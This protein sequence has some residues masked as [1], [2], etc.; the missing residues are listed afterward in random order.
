MFFPR[1]RRK[2]KPVFVLLAIVFGLGFVALGVGTGVSGTSVGDIL[3]DVFSAGGS[4]QASVDDALKKVEEN[5]KDPD[6]L[7]A[8]ADA[9]QAENRTADAIAT[10]ERYRALKP[11]DVD[12][13]KRL[14]NLYTF[15]AQEAGQRAQ[16][17]Q[18]A[19]QQQL[20]GQTFGPSPDSEL[21]QA[22]GSDAI[23]QAIRQR[24]SE[25]LAAVSSQVQVAY[26]QV[27]AVYQE[28]TLLEPE[29]PAN[30]LQLGQA[31]QIAG[32][33]ASAITAYKAFLE[34]SPDDAVAPQVR[35]QLEALEP[36]P[37]EVTAGEGEDATT[38]P[39][40]TGAA[41]STAGTG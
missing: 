28:L 7:I 34:L 12:T 8:L 14:A 36:T 35:A 26:R 21:G 6:A 39:A 16:L 41:A 2:A 18:A 31:S 3:S 25:R 30:F 22:L 32:D 9:Y 37:P 40:D 1:L 10:L 13:V 17:I 24:A 38:A 20:F 29:E 5:P 4:G 19:A 11:K 27:S 33:T 15:Q 23:A